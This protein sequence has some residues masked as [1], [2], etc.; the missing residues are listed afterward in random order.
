M[1]SLMHK[2]CYKAQFIMGSTLSAIY[3]RFCVD[4]TYDTDIG[5]LQI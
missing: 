1:V 5:F 2:N 3:S 4:N